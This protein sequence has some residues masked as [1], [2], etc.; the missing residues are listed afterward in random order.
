MLP[1]L[2][3]VCFCVVLWLLFAFFAVALVPV[4]LVA[5]GAGNTAAKRPVGKLWPGHRLSGP[6]T[7][8][9]LH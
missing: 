1:L 7:M 9:H 5:L 6:V 4:C 3:G 8:Y 2:P